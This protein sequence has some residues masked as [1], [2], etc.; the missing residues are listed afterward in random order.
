[1]GTMYEYITAALI[2][3]AV[4]TLVTVVIAVVSV[5]VLVFTNS[6][7][8][9]LVVFLTLS[10]IAI[11]EAIMWYFNLPSTADRDS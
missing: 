9:A 8:T 10:V 5:M 4:G 7:V 3:I 6:P 2:G 11:V 1:M